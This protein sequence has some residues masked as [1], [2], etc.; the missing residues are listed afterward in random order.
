MSEAALAPP[1][2]AIPGR[3]ALSL[4]AA[5]TGVSDSARADVGR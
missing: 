2:F 3:D 1:P 4:L 5:S